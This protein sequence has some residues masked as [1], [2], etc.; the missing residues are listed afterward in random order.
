MYADD[1]LPGD[2]QLLRCSRE[3][4]DVVPVSDSTQAMSAQT[5]VKQGD[6]LLIKQIAHGS[7]LTRQGIR[8]CLTN[9]TW[10]RQ[11]PAGFYDLRT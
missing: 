6:R 1:D 8:R 5:Q 2:T 4:R 7:F 3:Q 10:S 9:K 11:F